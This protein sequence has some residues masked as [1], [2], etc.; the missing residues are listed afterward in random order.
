MNDPKEEMDIL[1]DKLIEA[2]LAKKGVENISNSNIPKLSNMT[3]EMVASIRGYRERL[4]AA[5]KDTKS[6]IEKFMQIIQADELYMFRRLLYTVM[7]ELIPK[8]DGKPISYR[9]MDVMFARLPRI[10]ATREAEAVLDNT[11]TVDT[12]FTC[13]ECGS[14]RIMERKIHT[15]HKVIHECYKLNG[16]V[17]ANYG[18]DPILY[19]RRPE[20]T[21]TVDYVCLY[22]KCVYTA[23]E[24][25]LVLKH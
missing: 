16:K 13:T 19:S 21:T 24:L 20:P 23:E 10:K 9:D 17:F 4:V 14:Y 22:C 1:W 25:M 8:I 5:Q 3:N 18:G 2:F 12:N 15:E 6:A 11:I 7:C